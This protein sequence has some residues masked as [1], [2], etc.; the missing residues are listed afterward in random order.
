MSDLLHEGPDSLKETERSLLA[1]EATVLRLM[2]TSENAA[3]EDTL[4]MDREPF[5]RWQEN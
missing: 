1:A 5:E 2:P 3:E 4:T